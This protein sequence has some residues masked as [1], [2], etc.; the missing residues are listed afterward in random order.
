MTA[1]DAEKSPVV[2]QLMR[3]YAENK[4]RL[5]GIV[6]HQRGEPGECPVCYANNVKARAEKGLE[7]D[8]FHKQTTK[9]ATVSRRDYSDMRR[10]HVPP[11]AKKEKAGTINE[12]EKQRLKIMREAMA[13][14]LLMRDGED[15]L[16]EG[17]LVVNPNPLIHQVL[18]TTESLWCCRRTLNLLKNALLLFGTHNLGRLAGHSLPPVEDRDLRITVIYQEEG[19]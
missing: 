11:L 14:Y 6:P 12:E 2:Q 5:V 1:E 15:K 10:H 7:G 13:Y 3:I 19:Q 16:V 4:E 17:N 18:C 9:R 8:G